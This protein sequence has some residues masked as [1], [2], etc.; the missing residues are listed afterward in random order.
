MYKSDKIV[1]N[2]QR[3]FLGFSLGYYQ[4]KLDGPL[5]YIFFSDFF[6]IL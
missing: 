1:H 5:E 4:E 2:N 6:I 3:T